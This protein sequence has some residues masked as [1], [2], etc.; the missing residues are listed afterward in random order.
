MF[1]YKEILVPFPQRI[2]FSELEELGKDRWEM[3]GVVLT[4]THINHEGYLYYFKRPLLE[5]DM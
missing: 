3:C 5:Y 2:K 4:E 1:E